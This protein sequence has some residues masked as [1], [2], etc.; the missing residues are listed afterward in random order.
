MAHFAISTGLHFF[1]GLKFSHIHLILIREAK[2]VNRQW[3]EE[4]KSVSVLEMHVHKRRHTD[5]QAN[6]LGIVKPPPIQLVQHLATN[7]RGELQPHAEH[8]HRFL[9]SGVYVK[10]V[11]ISTHYWLH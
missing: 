5:E 1:G 2:L 11:Y 7:H 9:W 6:L 8:E 4:C 10:F 3:L